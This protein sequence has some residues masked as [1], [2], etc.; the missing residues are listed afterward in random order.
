MCALKILLYFILTADVQTELFTLFIWC[1]KNI[2]IVAPTA[3]VLTEIH[4]LDKL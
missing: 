2:I 1:F 3:H 4:T